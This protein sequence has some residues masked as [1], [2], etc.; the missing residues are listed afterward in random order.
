M[1]GL[2]RRWGSGTAN[3]GGSCPREAALD[4]ATLLLFEFV[5]PDDAG[6]FEASDIDLWMLSLVG[7]RE[8]TLPEYADLL[9]P[10]GWRLTRSQPTE[11]QSIIEARA[12]RHHPP[13]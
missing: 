1:P 2:S 10:A 7:G 9:E 6:E 11:V 13:T 8:R 3:A 5:V 4:D 12:G